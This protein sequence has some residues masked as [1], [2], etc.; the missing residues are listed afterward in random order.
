MTIKREE[1][2]KHLV[3]LSEVT[4]GKRLDPIHPGQVLQ[5]DFLKPLGISVYAL[6][7]KIRV[8]RSRINDIV[9]GRR[10]ITTETALRLSRYFGTSAE[11]WINLQTCYDL[12]IADRALGGRIDS[13]IQPRAV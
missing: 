13:E 4:D 3:D 10:A 6:A 12:D 11:F 8:P 1:L 2:N 5:G 9:R 7:V